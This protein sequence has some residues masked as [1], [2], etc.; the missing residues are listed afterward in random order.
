MRRAAVVPLALPVVAAL[1]MGAA[2]SSPAAAPVVRLGIDGAHNANVSVA[3]A[4]FGVVVTWAA[5]GSTSTDVYA[6]F[7]RDGGASF[8]APIRVND[9]PGDV[10]A[11]GEQAPRVAIGGGVHVAWS[12]RSGETPVIRAASAPGPDHAFQP[13]ISVHPDKLR[14]IRGWTSLAVDPRGAVHVAWLDGRGAAEAA[15]TH[16]TPRQDLYQ[17]VRGPDGALREARVATDVCFCCKTA[18]A[19]GPDDAVYVAWR[20]I[21]PGSLRDIAVARSDDGGRTF[22][23]P[24]RLSEDGWVLDGCPDDGPSL[25]TGAAKVLH[26]AWPTQVSEQTGKGIFYSYS[27][28][29]GRTFAPRLRLDEAGNAAHPQIAAAE[30][31]V[32]VVWDEAAGGGARRIRMRSIDAASGAS[33]G[34]ALRPVAT[35]GTGVT[36]TYPAVAAVPGGAVVVWTETSG[37]RSTVVVAR[38]G[39]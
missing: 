22:G 26:V 18:V 17:A 28:D 2:S 23:A 39:P 38:A 29:G 35:L 15:P 32:F 16:A 6:A 20:H 25:A 8:N 19:A 27:T 11:S 21:Y 30:G 5:R 9:V 3:A 13:A 31:R 36:T 12:S 33:A 10:R 37:S 34:P 24:V 4:G 1:T 14:G 7:S